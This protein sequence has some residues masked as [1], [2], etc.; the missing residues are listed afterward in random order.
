MDVQVVKCVIP[1]SSSFDFALS[2]ERYNF[3]KKCKICS[4]GGSE[5][6]T[7]DQCD[8]TLSLKQKLFLQL[9]SVKE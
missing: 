3:Y 4:I 8:Q 6:W 9:I 5:I 7:H 2:Y 1:A